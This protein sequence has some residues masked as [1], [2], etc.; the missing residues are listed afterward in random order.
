MSPLASKTSSLH[1]SPARYESTLASIA[2]KAET[3]NLQPGLVIKAVRISCESVSGT[4]S[5]R[6]ASHGHQPHEI[7]RLPRSGGG[8][9]GGSAL[10]LASDHRPVRLLHRTGNIAGPASAHARSSWKC[11]SLPNDLASCCLS[12][13]PHEGH[14]EPLSSALQQLLPS[15]CNLMP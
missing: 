5:E 8:F 13:M 2:E 15:V 9:C 14:P 1:L 7:S 4:S 3:M 6:S 11:I 12:L 10:Y